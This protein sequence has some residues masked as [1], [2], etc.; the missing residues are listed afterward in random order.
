MPSFVATIAKDDLV[1]E[2]STLAVLANHS[3]DI[4]WNFKVRRILEVVEKLNWVLDHEVVTVDRILCILLNDETHI[5]G[6]FSEITFVVLLRF[7]FGGSICSIAGARPSIASRISAASS[8]P[9]PSSP[10]TSIGS[11]ISNNGFLSKAAAV[12]S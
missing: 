6:L 9:M 2:V 11:S 12:K 1:F 3:K 10:S 5:R 8:S 7:F 4:V